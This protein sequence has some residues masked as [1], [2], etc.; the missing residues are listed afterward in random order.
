[1]EQINCRRSVLRTLFVGLS[2]VVV[3]LVFTIFSN[4]AT[5]GTPRGG[6]TPVV[7]EQYATASDGTPLHWDV[8]TPSKPGPW[9]AVLVIHGGNFYGGGITY[10]PSLVQCAQDLAA[11]GYIAFS[12]EYR[13]APPG[14][15]PGQNSDGR[16][17][18]Q[19]DDVRLAIL[20]ARSDPRCNGQ[21]GAV[22]GSAGGSHAAYTASTGTRGQDRLDVAVSLSGAYDLSDF[23]LNPN[24]DTFTSNVTNYVGVTSSNVTALRAASP[25]WVAD[26]TA[27]PIF[28]ANSLEDPMPYSQ[29]NDMMQHLDALGL[30]NYNS[31]SYSGA[32][33]SFDNWPNAKAQSLSFLADGFS[34]TPPPPPL[35]APG[36][37][38]S[39]QKLL[40]VSTRTDVG[41]GDNVTVGGFI[42]TGSTAKR[43]SLLAV[44]PS[45][46]SAG[47]TGVLSN[48]TLTLYD[49]TGFEMEFNDNFSPLPGIPNSLAPT[50]PSESY[51]TAVLPPGEYTAVMNGVNNATGIGLV[52]LYDQQPQD[53]LVA[54]ISTRGYIANATDYLIGG[55]IVGGSTPTQVI[56]LALGPSLGSAGI[57]NPLPNP[58]L[59]LYDSNGTQLY[60]NDNW[61][62]TQA[63]QIQA[64]NLAPTSPL[65][66]AIV[67]T[68]NP[69]AYTAVVKDAGG[70]SGV[71]LVEVYNLS[72]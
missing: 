2:L 28:M 40:N 59:T 64:T 17:P 14:K 24:I 36:A 20:A 23:S 53:S 16:F 44:G 42:I 30:V 55:F 7:N 52:E 67:Q 13:L 65:E 22:G 15:L 26:S 47:V 31:T 8:Y 37:G 61:Q 38:D 54:N 49:S 45:L 1:M 34:G 39:N 43:V 51:L 63:Q 58:A 46:T 29:L 25:A 56:A 68:L 33:H 4:R 57:S 41:T 6:N 71:A 27:S 9:P 66:S 60:Y 62:T 3:S 70:K 72:N 18:D 35:P 48:P 10:P 19:T 69:G 32:D 50:N 11:A 5:A 21:V 12:I